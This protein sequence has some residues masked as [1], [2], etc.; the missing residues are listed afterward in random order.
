[1][2]DSDGFLPGKAI[3]RRNPDGFQVKAT[4]SRRKKTPQDGAL[5]VFKQTLEGVF[6]FPE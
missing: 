6:K 4:Q 5:T 3:W 2:P 1:M